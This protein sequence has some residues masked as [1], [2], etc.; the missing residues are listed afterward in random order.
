MTLAGIFE[1]GFRQD[2]FVLYWFLT[3]IPFVA[4]SLFMLS[5]VRWLKRNGVSFLDALRA[6]KSVAY[7]TRSGYDVTGIE[8]GVPHN[9][10]NGP[11]GPRVLKALRDKKEIESAVASL[12]AEDRSLLPDV[13]PTVGALV[14][15]VVTLAPLLQDVDR[16]VDRDDLGELEERIVELQSRNDRDSSAERT[17]SLLTRQRD[18]LNDLVQRRDALEAR[19]ESAS[20]L[21]QNFRLDLRKI[22]STGIE[23]SMNDVNSATQE[24][25]ALA[26]EIGHVLSAADDVKR[27]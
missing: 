14:E 3:G 2:E 12:S 13:L 18:T 11:Y 15:Q 1:R 10:L 4:G 24:A 27:I 5:Q 23:S 25:R 8:S 16:D 21:L 17:L 7:Q 26:K 20:L 9:V 22:A 19:M 6:K